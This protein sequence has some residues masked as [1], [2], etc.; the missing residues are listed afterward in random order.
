MN[1]PEIKVTRINNRW[2]ARLIQD[3]TVLD[4]MACSHQADI[5]RI[6][7]EMLTW[8]DKVGG[9]SEYASKVRSRYSDPYVGKIWYQNHLEMER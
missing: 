9:S 8:Y 7:R 4:E 6:S 3:G 5:G 2:H 1:E